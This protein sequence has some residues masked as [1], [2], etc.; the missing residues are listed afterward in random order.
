MTPIGL[1]LYT[2]VSSF[3]SRLP[4]ASD[5][6]AALVEIYVLCGFLDDARLHDKSLRLLDTYIDNSPREHKRYEHAPYIW[7]NTP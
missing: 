3:Q 7:N 2:D 6:I 1:A 5:T 4:S